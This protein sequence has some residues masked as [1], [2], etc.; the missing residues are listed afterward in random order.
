MTVE[1]RDAS[2]EE[3]LSGLR[4][5]FGLRYRNSASLDRRV[6][7]TFQGSLERVVRRL[8]EGYDFV[9]KT[10]SDTFEVLV[11]GTAKSGGAQSAP[12]ATPRRRMD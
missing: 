8:L 4:A 2:V 5:R 9:L 6:N 3:V 1:A 12:S 11:I 7:G 10:N